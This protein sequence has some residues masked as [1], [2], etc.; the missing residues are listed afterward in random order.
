[1]SRT[2]LYGA[3]ALFGLSLVFWAVHDVRPINEESDCR[4]LRGGWHPDAPLEIREGCDF[5]NKMT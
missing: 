1:M 4:L 3:I 2:W 5:P